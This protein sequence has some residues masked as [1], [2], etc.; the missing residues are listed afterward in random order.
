MDEACATALALID[1]EAF[2]VLQPFRAC[3]D[4]F[5]GVVETLVRFS[6]P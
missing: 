1:D 5:H 2:D 6:H 4:G 3:E